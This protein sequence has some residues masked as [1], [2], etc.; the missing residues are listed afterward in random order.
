[1]LAASGSSWAIVD[2]LIPSHAAVRSAKGL[3]QE[4]LE[5]LPWLPAMVNRVVDSAAD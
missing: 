3:P 5:Q 1:M 2:W 4:S